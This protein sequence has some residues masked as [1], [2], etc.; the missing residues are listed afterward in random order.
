MTAT[1]NR[2]FNYY[3]LYLFLL[4]KYEHFLTSFFFIIFSSPFQ[5]FLNSCYTISTLLFFP[6]KKKGFQLIKFEF[7]FQLL[8]KNFNFP[9][10]PNIQNSQS[11]N[12]QN[13][14]FQI[15]NFFQNPNFQNLQN[16]N[17]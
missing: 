1:I 15:P 10:N 11:S 6:K 9:Q 13:P 8:A 12:P 2:Y 5:H 7:S 4:Y 3:F 17:S 16:F 14:N